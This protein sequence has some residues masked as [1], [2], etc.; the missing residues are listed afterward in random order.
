MALPFEP[1]E[2]QVLLEAMTFDERCATL[3]A[4]LE[5]D[6]AGDDEPHGLQ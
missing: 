5:I 4:L 2:K 3:T 1:G 6:A